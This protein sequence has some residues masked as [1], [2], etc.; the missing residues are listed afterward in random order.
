[1]EVAGHF[2]QFL[3]EDSRVAAS[4]MWDVTSAGSARGSPPQGDT[5]EAFCFS[6]FLS[7]RQS[8]EKEMYLQ[9]CAFQTG[10]VKLVFHN[11]LI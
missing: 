9:I 3:W 5:Q 7:V 8:G 4:E 10:I 2:L 11:R 1:M 6:N